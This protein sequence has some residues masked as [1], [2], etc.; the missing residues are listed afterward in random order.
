[1]RYYR[2]FVVVLSSLLLLTISAAAVAEVEKELACETV[3]F[4]Y[5]LWKDAA[6]GK[7]PNGIERAAWI[8]Q[9]SDGPETFQKWRNSGER[10]K[11]FWR[12]PVPENVVALAHT[13]PNNRD[14]K[15][16]YKDRN[17]AKRLRIHVYV[18]SESGIWVSN[19]SGEISQL[20]KYEDFKKTATSCLISESVQ[21][22][23][24]ACN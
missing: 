24:K 10:S 15:P 1:M 23:S 8:I 16:S 12:G 21:A 18:I 22:A 14:Y 11:E 2:N 9:K 20:T 7:D 17:V 5:S 13:H 6:Y 3:T 4:F 19:P